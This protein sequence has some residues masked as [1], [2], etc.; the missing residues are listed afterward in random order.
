MLRGRGPEFLLRLKGSDGEQQTLY[1]DVAAHG[2]LRA[3]HDLAAFMHE[4]CPPAALK[5]AILEV[6]S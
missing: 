6:R 4:S 1:V 5:V 3:P 2:R